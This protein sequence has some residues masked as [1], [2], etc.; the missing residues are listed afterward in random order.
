MSG[1]V[2]SP[3]RSLLL[4]AVLA[5]A[6]LVP[7]G[8]RADT[9]IQP[10]AEVSSGAGQCTLNFVFEGGG[11][12]YI[13]TAG[14]CSDHAGDVMKDENDRRIGTVAFRIFEGDDD[15]S[16]IKIDSARSGEVDPSVRGWGGPTGI[17][18]SADEGLGDVILL[19]GYGE[20]FSLAGPLRA[21]PGILEAQTDAFYLALAP[22]VFGDSGG[23]VIDWATGKAVGLVSGIGVTVPPSTLEGPTIDGTLKTLAR[24]GFNVTLATAGYSR[25]LPL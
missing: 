1:G 24:H 6:V 14:H 22:A 3:T 5:I 19:S 16:L 25:E 2:S 9:L 13:G 4:V 17:T 23:P 20:G 18:T 21:R 8:S 7:L 11:N 12:K 15:F 10:G